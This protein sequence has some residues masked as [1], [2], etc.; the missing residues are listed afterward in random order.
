MENNHMRSQEELEKHYRQRRKERFEKNIPF[1]WLWLQRIIHPVLIGILRAGHMISG[2]S[3][4]IVGDCLPY[5]NSPTIYACTHRGW[6]DIEMAFTAIRKQC[7]LLLGDPR[8]VYRSAEGVMLFL[9]GV[10]CMD[11]D[12]KSDRHI[13]KELCVR[14]L[15]QGGSLLIYP[16]GAWNITENLP[17]MLL[18]SGTAE[19]AIRSKADIIPMAIEIAGDKFFVKFGERIDCSAYTIEQKQELTD[20]LRDMMASLLWDIWGH[21]PIIQRRSLPSNY[22]ELF[23]ENFCAQLRKDI[24]TLEDI[25]ITRYKPKNS[26]S[27]EEAFMHLSTVEPTKNSAFLFNKRLKGTVVI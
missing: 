2:K 1:R 13:G 11:S 12:V 27:P 20:I 22:G 24:Y 15:K 14:L 23:I 25:Q 17:V 3:V 26:T 6:D 10:I 4:H 16:E 9:N 7:H 8:E 21:F 19:M 5:G 18:F